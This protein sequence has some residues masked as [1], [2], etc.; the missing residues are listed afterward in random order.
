MTRYGVV[1]TLFVLSMITYIDRAC[2]SAAKD[3][4]ANALALSDQAMGFVFGAFALGYALAQVPSGQ[5]AD[6]RGPRIALTVVVMGWSALTTLTGAAWNLASLVVVRFLF[7]V[8][9]AG[10]FP[11]S[12]RAFYNWLPVHERGRANGILFSGSRIGAAL[13][14]PLLAWML[15]VWS[16]RATFLILGTVGVGWALFWFV[17]FRDHPPVPVP[18][19]KETSTPPVSLRDAFCST[20]MAPA[21]TQYFASNFTFFICLSWMHP[22]LK[23]QYHLPDTEAAAY[24]M[25]PLLVGATSQW[26][27]GFLVDWLYR[28]RWRQWSRRAPAILGFMVSAGGVLAVASAQT[29]GVAV[30]YFT[31]ATFGAE[32]TISPSW[33]YCADVAGENTGSVSA[34]MNMLGNV[35]A[36]VSAS[37]FPY[38]YGLTGSAETYFGVAAALNM[39]AVLCWLRMRSTG[40]SGGPAEILTDRNR[41]LPRP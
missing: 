24:M 38:L 5:F 13:A 6:R 32:M 33:A 19:E 4:I 11:G 28:S 23:R 1:A 26:I 41:P 29:P 2:I 37:A 3:P 31:L 15:G 36:F 18:G 9:E 14:F 21:M 25:V 35:G 16:W 27:T 20:A 12:V 10:A 34:A 22:Y 17:F 30:M 7:G 8:A 40:K 39:I